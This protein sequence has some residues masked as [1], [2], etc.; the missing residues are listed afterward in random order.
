[1]FNIYV[2]EKRKVYSVHR[3]SLC[4]YSK[5]FQR[6]FHDTRASSADDEFVL[7]AT[8]ETAFDVVVNWLY[9]G[10]LGLVS[11]YGIDSLYLVYY[12]AEKL[13]ISLLGNLV[14]DN[15]RERYRGDPK[16]TESYPG[17]ERIHEVYQ[18]TTP[19]SPLRRFVVQA[20]YWRI[21]K[22][23]SKVEDYITG[24]DVTGQ[25]VRDF[26]EVTKEKVGDTPGAF[27]A[28]DPRCSEPCSFHVHG[29]GRKCSKPT[30]GRP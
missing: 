10:R 24:T 5:F 26:I 25:F 1:M 30:A 4:L 18:N 29:G 16:S 13:G 21:M 27:R 14:M 28:F 17:I 6:K 12:E 3:T 22:E 7:P 9:R 11:V 8:E 19:D 15:I 20:A 2:G 23:G